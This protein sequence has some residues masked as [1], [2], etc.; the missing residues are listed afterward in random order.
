MLERAGADTFEY[1]LHGG[2]GPVT[3]QWHFFEQS[4]LP[5]AVQ[6]WE[7][8]PGGSEGRHA[9]SG[10]GEL[11]ELYLVLD[12][13]GRM[14]VGDAVYDVDRGDSVLARPGA[15]HDLLNTGDGPLRILMIWGPPGHA[16]FSDFGS[17]QAARAAKASTVSGRGL[18]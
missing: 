10:D 12:G 11:E 16:D 9:H 6:T 5:V 15:E 4:R 18:P 2:H 7:L 14:H 17:A 1:D 3:M 13:T 8:A